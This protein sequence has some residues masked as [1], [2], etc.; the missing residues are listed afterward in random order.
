VPQIMGPTEEGN[1][2][3]TVS[4]DLNIEFI[5][6][7]IVARGWGSGYLPSALSEDNGNISPELALVL[8]SYHAIGQKIPSDDRL[9]LSVEAIPGVAEAVANVKRYREW[10]CHGQRYHQDAIL[11]HFRLQCWTLKPAFTEREYDSGIELG[12]YVNPMFD[13]K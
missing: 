1:G 5:A 13:Q 11:K 12:C 3:S 2:S 7:E 10:I 6:E 9:N 4:A 8:L